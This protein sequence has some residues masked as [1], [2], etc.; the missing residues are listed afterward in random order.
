MSGPSCQP[1]PPAGAGLLHP[2]LVLGVLAVPI[3]SASAIS[4]ERA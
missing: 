4:G 1:P 3:F 2:V